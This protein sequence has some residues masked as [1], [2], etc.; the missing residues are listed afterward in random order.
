MNPL[1]T[2]NDRNRFAA[3]VV[4]LG[5]VHAVLFVQGNEGATPPRLLASFALSTTL[6][7]LAQRVRRRAFERRAL[8]RL[9]RA[10]AAAPASPAISSE[11][12]R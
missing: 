1:T 8:D 7:A 3:S 10:R 6:L 9:E 5:V 11:V 2:S 4:L 12:P